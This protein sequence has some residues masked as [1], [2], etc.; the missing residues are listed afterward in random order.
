V[1][2]DSRQPPIGEMTMRSLHIF[3]AALLLPMG[4]AKAQSL[5]AQWPLDSGSRVRIQSPI[6]SNKAQQGTVMSTRGDTLLFQSGLAA[7]TTAIP[8]RDITS[9]DI[10]QGRHTRKAKGA[11]LGFVL[12]AG[13]AAAYAA[14]TWKRSNGFDFGRD[15]DAAVMAVPGGLV[16]GL[17]GLLIGAQETESWMRVKVPS[18]N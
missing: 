18:G 16:G 7:A 15:G 17:V 12:G 13:T 8:L 11:L 3:V 4:V 9:I 10:L 14:A 6:F 1:P 2:D 5:A